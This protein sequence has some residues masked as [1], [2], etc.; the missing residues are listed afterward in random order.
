MWYLY[1]ICTVNQIPDIVMIHRP[2]KISILSELTVCFE[3][4]F[5]KS[6]QRKENRY[7]C[8][9]LSDIQSTGFYSRYASE[10]VDTPLRT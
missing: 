7:G 6:T 2:H 1:R 3:T 4:N 9:L 5:E 8:S 10:W